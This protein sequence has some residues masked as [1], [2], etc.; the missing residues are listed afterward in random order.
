M[1]DII[2][3]LEALKQSVPAEQFNE[4]VRKVTAAKV[5]PAPT[6]SR[7]RAIQD[8]LTYLGAPCNILGFRYL[9]TGILLMYDANVR[10]GYTTKI[11]YPEIAAA[12]ETTPSRVERGIRHAIERIWDNC[13]PDDLKKF[14]GNSVSYYR[15]RPSNSAF[16]SRMV[17][18]LRR[19]PNGKF[20]EV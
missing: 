12:H 17:D 4:A 14:F 9:T 5:D 16:M 1:S 8:A 13:D 20:L 11:L 3:I 6:V 2:R 7:E 10:P 18:L 15:G 19:N